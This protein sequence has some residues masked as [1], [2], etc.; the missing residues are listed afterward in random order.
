MK[1]SPQKGNPILGKANYKEL[2]TATSN[3]VKCGQAVEQVNAFW[4][5]PGR[6]PLRC[7]LERFETTARRDEAE[8][9]DKLQSTFARVNVES[10]YNM[11]ARLHHL[12]SCAG[13]RFL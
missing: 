8:A 10:Q 7:Q 1:S 11:E 13:S 9:R 5:E 12:A 2:P 3:P 4:Q 6:Q